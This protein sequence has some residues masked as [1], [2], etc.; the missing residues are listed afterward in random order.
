MLR[1]AHFGMNA[2]QTS[3]YFSM[4]PPYFEESVSA[5]PRA[6]PIPEG[7][8]IFMIRENSNT[9]GE[10]GAEEGPPNVG[11]EDNDGDAFF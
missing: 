9:A 2:S 6:H 8:P 5:W 4:T 1:N 11:G 3:K 10:A 7:N